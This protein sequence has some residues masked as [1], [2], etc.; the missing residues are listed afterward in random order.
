MIDAAYCSPLIRA[1]SKGLGHVPLID[2]NPRGGEKINFDPPQAMRFKHRTTVERVNAR[3]K[4]NFGADRINV[5]GHGKVATH[6]MFAV[7]ALT[8]DQLLR[9]IT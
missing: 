7:R 8:A 1:H 9:F 5:R 2:H 4:D 3:L 6:L